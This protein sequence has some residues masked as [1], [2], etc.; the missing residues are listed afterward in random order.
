MTKI[1]R[2]IIFES[3]TYIIEDEIAEPFNDEMRQQILA[4]YEGWTD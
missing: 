2:K 4:I 3:V 1:T